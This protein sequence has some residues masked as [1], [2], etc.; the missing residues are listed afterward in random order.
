MMDDINK[1]QEISHKGEGR[2][3]CSMEFKTATIK[4]AQE[5]SIHNSANKFKVDQ[6]PSVS[7]SKKKRK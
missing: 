4:Y 6:K 1:N 2:Q 3:K 5:N 7:G